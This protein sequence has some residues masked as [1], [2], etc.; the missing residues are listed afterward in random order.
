MRWLKTVRGSA[1]RPLEPRSRRRL[2]TAAGAL[3]LASAVA[4]A[5]VACHRDAGQRRPV[6]RRGPQPR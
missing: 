2:V 4:L 3:A 1:R 6:A 5:T